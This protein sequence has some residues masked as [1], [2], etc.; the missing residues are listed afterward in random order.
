M[1]YNLQIGMLKLP[2]CLLRRFAQAL[3]GPP[4]EVSLA[5]EIKKP[6]RAWSL[7]TRGVLVVYEVTADL[8]RAI[9]LIVLFAPL[10]VTAPAC[11]NGARRQEWLHYLRRAC[12]TPPW[13]LALCAL[14]QDP[15]LMK[16]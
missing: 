15:I 3:T 14:A 5:T 4:R 11:L 6:N 1:G 2:Y 9:W 8:L 12:C 10:A 16:H 7:I 13:E